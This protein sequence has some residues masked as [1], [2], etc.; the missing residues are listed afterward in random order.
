MRPAPPDRA[1]VEQAY[2]NSRRAVR[3]HLWFFLIC[4]IVALVMRRLLNFPPMLSWTVFA[5]AG[6]VFSGDLIRLVY[7]WIKLWRLP[8]DR[9]TS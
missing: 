7:R 8:P 1:A 4:I 3:G 2:E 9:P 5:A 6:A